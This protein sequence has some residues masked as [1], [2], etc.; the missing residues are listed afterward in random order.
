MS[1]STSADSVP[2]CDDSQNALGGLL[3]VLTPELADVVKAWPT[4]PEAIR[5]GIVAMVKASGQQ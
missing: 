1:D 2:S 4:L 3:G 5:A